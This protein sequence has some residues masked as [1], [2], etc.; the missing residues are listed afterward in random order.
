MST[1]KIT[2][3]PPVLTINANTAN[4]VLVGVDIPS[5]VTGQITLT[6]LARGLYSNNNLLVGNTNVFLPNAVAQFTG[7]SDL[8]IQTSIQNIAP[9]GS[10]DMVVTADNGTD[11]TYFIDVGMAGSGYVFAGDDLNKPN[12]GYIIMAGGNPTDPGG[13]LSIGTITDGKDINIF[14]GGLDAANVVA[15]FGH[16]TGLKLNK[17]PLTFADGTSQNTAVTYSTINSEISSNVATLRGEITSNAASANSVINS[18]ISSNVATVNTFTQAAFNKANNA[19][20]NATGIFAG[21]LTITGNTQVA[22][23]NTANLSVVGTANVSGTLNVV[24]AVTMNSTLVL[25]NTNFNAT[26]A[27]MTIKATANT[28]VPAL[29]GYMIHVSGKANT[30][31]RIVSDAFGANTYPLIA[32]RAARGTVDAPTATQANDVLFRISSGGWGTTGFAP[33][34]SGR[35]DFMATENY[36]DSARGSRITFFNVMEGTNTITQIASFNSN[37]AVFSGTVV[38]TKGVVYNPRL[39]AGAQTAITID[40]SSDS[41]IKAT[42][43]APITIGFSNYTAGKIVEMWLTNTAGNGQTITHGCLANNSTKGTTS[44]SVA[45]GQSAF[46]KYFSIDGDQANTFV[47]ITYN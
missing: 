1:V 20:A 27:A 7:N 30:P 26:E 42:F 33:L 12:D 41:I 39:P 17:K 10:G 22:S 37:N 16:T 32:G 21:D 8:Y 28:Q 40:F 34:G 9:K 2:D 44:F 5:D 46:L 24:G 15:T 23:L 31:T 43:A 3:L 38:P 4:T 6:T 13:N 18:R 11:T 29:D 19:L 14:Q 36:T 45:A 35:I 25:A 47:A